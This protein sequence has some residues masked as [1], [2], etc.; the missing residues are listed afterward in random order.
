MDEKQIIEY[1]RKK[2]YIDGEY[3]CWD[4]VME[5]CKDLYDLELPE[6]PVTEVQTEFK[7]KLISNFKHIVVPKGEEQEGDVIV[8]SLF[9]NQHA[10][11]M[12]N[13]NNY[14]HLCREGVQVRDLVAL[15]SNYKVYRAV[16]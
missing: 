5:V 12:I 1:M 2:R 16:R 15:V 8:F 6:Y 7:N 3:I 13:K 4:F 9:A 11:V 10:G 14:I